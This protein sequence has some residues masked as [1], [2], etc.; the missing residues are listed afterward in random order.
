VLSGYN[1]S[2][3]VGAPVAVITNQAQTAANP[4]TSSTR[5]YQ[6]S[7]NA[8]P[9]PTQTLSVSKTGTGTGTVTSSPAGIDCGATCSASFTTGSSVALT[10]TPSPGSRFGS[11]SGACSGTST[12]CNVTMNTAKSVTANFIA[13]HQLTVSKSG[14]GTVTSNPSGI[15]CGATCSALYDQGTQVTLSATPASGYRFSGWSGAGCSGTGSCVVTMDAAKSVT[16][17]FIPQQQLTVSK[18]GSGTVTSSPSGINCGATCS[19]LYDQGTTV[20]LSASP[21][22]GW[23]FEGWSGEGC[24][25]TGN[26][27]VTMDAARNVTAAFAQDPPATH[28]LSVLRTGT[29]SGTVTSTPAG[30]DCGVDC[31][32]SYSDGTAVTLTAAPAA[33]SRFGGWSG[34]CTGS[35]TTCNVTMSAARSVTATFIA[36][37]QLTVS[38]SGSGSVSSNPAGIS[39]GGD[40]TQLYDQGTTVTLSAS[41]AAGWHF[42]GWSGEGC[43]GTGNCQV[44][45]DAARNV[46]ASF[47]QDPPGTFSLSVSRTGTGSGTVTSTPAGIDCGEDCSQP[48]TDDG[49]PETVTLTATPAAGSRFGGWSG[50][51]AGSASTCNVTM[52]A[53]RSVTAT[54][55]AQHQLTV[56]TSG[57]GSVSSNPAG[58]SCGGDCSEPYDQGTPV[59]LS[60]SPAPGWHLDH[61]GD[62]C[63]GSGACEITMNA[64]SSVTA[65][66]AQDAP[67]GGTGTTGGSGAAPISPITGP[68]APTPLDRTA[69]GLGALRLAPTAFRAA[70]A[71]PSARA[72][73]VGTIVRYV[74]TEAA[75]IT[76][77][78]DRAAGGR[79]VAGRCVRPTSA[80]SGRPRCI[81]WVRMRGSF[82]RAALAGA[83]ALRFT[84]RL[85][86]RRLATGLYRLVADATDAAGNR[87]VVRRASFRIVR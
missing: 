26:C 84:G 63:S 49:T 17:N 27:Q 70:L 8:A 37:H 57:S 51:C 54:F 13:Q 24:S 67:A 10:A 75:R 58:I 81:R 72:A 23:H 77:R 46:T 5:N 9:S 65:T 83:N 39:C 31:S 47:A 28:T 20:T 1:P 44:T 14:S 68:V 3:C 60:A 79:R 53:A 56:S 4:G 61:W 69:P 36:Q 52:S 22:A 55:I 34:S 41:P 80:N 21:A 12:T 25:G 7:T 64:A 85:A 29:G 78:V 82:S 38:T 73:A 59:T 2:G 11:W 19:A 87:S 50:D 42:D 16:A 74:L 66:F 40:C 48:Y 18:N 30:I 43:S 15:N 71:G 62:A 86:G 76:F 45:M 6:V 32:E 35:S 33:G